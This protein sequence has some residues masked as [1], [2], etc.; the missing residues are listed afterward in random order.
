[1]NELSEKFPAFFGEGK[2]ESN[3]S[4]HL[5]QKLKLNK[6]QPRVAKVYD[7][8][9]QLTNYETDMYQQLRQL[10]REA[11]TTQSVR[12]HGHENV[13]QSQTVEGKKS[14]DE[15]KTSVR[16]EPEVSKSQVIDLVH[17]TFTH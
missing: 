2:R 10:T 13:S 6:A 4:F 15:K 3:R 16:Y 1:M 9:L 12:H 5:R 8:L 14:S 17:R 11:V 7:Q